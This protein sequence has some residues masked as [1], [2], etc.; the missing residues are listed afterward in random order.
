[1]S[2]AHTITVEY[3][4]NGW[5]YGSGLMDE[6]GRNRWV[7]TNVVCL[8]PAVACDGKGEPPVNA[9]A[10]L[11]AD[12]DEWISQF[13]GRYFKSIREA[14]PATVLY[15]G[16]D[17]MGTWG[18]PARKEIMQGA[19]P[20]LDAIYPSSVVPQQR[21]VDYTQQWLGDKPM[22]SEM[23]FAATPDSALFRYPGAAPGV[24]DF[25]TQAARGQQYFESES[26]AVN[27]RAS[28]GTYP[29][30][31][32]S[33]WGLTDFWNEKIDW[34]LV[35]LN[36]NA[37]DGHEAVTGKVPCSTPLEMMTCGGEERNYGDAISKV[38][39]A[40][41]L[42]LPIA[43]RAASETQGSAVPARRP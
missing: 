29:Y 19:A 25:P 34:G 20:Y 35:S 21:Q 18:A 42:W 16:P 40:N 30:V 3:V 28:N 23:M 24:L 26:A 27:M 9:S 11:G 15:L 5:M 7:G 17:S 37:Y 31:G 39:Q 6:D 10:K 13:A 4:Q 14:I 41:G 43:N 33:F 1:L 12:V 22:I 38:T 36:D 32:V 2:G 8:Q